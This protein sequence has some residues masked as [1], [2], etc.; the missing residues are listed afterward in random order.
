MQKI[1]KVPDRK[2]R[3]AAEEVTNS[4]EEVRHGQ[5]FIR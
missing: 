2:Y 5:D 3:K 4:T 1:P